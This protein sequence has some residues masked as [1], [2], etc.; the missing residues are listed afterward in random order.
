MISKKQVEKKY[1]ALLKNV[2]NNDYYKIDLTNR[3]NCYT[4]ICGHITKTRDVDA[5]VTPFMHKCEKCGKVAYSTFYKDISPNQK[6]T[7][8]WYR[9]SL[10]E[11]MKL[12]HEYY[13]LDHVLNGGLLVRKIKNL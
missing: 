8:E 9:P 1:A 4:C 3:V 10:M 11:C 12:R 6:P 5:G 7:E 13:M 2:A